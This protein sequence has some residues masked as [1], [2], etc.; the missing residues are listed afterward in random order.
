MKR[1][2]LILCTAI[3]SSLSALGM[4][5]KD[6]QAQAYFLSDKMAYELNLSPQQ[7]DQVYQVNL[8]YFLNVSSPHDIDGLWWSYRNTD[9]GYILYDWQWRLYRAADYFFRPLSWVRG[10]WHCSIWNRYHRDYF[11]YRRPAIYAHYHGGLWHGRHHHSPSPFIGHRPP[12]HHGG[13]NANFGK[14]GKPGHHPGNNHH[15][16]GGNDGYRPGNNNRPGGNDGYR[17]G[18]HHRPGGNDGYK[19]GNN[20]RPGGNDGYKP[21]NNGN[22]RPSGGRGGSSMSNSRSTRNQS[23]STSSNSRS[24]NGGRDRR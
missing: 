24:F 1:Y 10:A 9:L 18:N 6:A 19:P 22:S 3:V 16:P 21:G 14:P 12:K 8:E 15:R 17:P 20:S 7:Y 2:I 5:F 11:F 13:M 23:G 4:N